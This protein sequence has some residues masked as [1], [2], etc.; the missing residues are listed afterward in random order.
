MPVSMKLIDRDMVLIQLFFEKEVLEV[1]QCFDG[2]ASPF[3]AVDRWMEVIDSPP[4]P[5]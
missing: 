3:L 5:C 4:Q 2:S 1:L